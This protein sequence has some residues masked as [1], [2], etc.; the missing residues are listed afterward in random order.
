MR[1]PFRAEAGAPTSPHSTN[2]VMVMPTSVKALA[3][4]K[5]PTHMGTSPPVATP[6]FVGALT[7]VGA[8]ASAR[9]APTQTPYLPETPS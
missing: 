6:A 4:V 2:A 9:T 7:S 8:P 1:L 5:T 3:L